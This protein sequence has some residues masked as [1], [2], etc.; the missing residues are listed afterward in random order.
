M[1]VFQ[2]LSQ[3]N[4]IHI[5]SNGKCNDNSNS[6]RIAIID[7]LKGY[8]II[9]VILGHMIVYTKP[10]NFESNFLFPLIYSFHMPL[11][12]AL[13][14]YL[15]Y[16]K[17]INYVWA[18]I[19]KKFKGLFI[20]YLVWNIIGLLIVDSF[21]TKQNIFQK[22]IESFYIYSNLWFLPV[23]FFSFILLIFYIFLE[24]LFLKMSIQKYSVPFYLI[25]YLIVMWVF[26]AQPPFQ[27]FL[28]IRWF[29]PFVF[30]GYITAKYKNYIF[31]FN[32]IMFPVSLFLF[33]ILLPFWDIRVIQFA[34]VG[35]T[36]LIINFILALFG[37]TISYYIVKLLKNTKIY[38]FLVFCGMFS[39]E[40]YVISNLLALIS[41]ITQ[42]RFW[43]GEGIVSLLSG[44]L[45]FTFISLI[46]SLILSYNQICSTLLFGRWVLKHP[47]RI[48]KNNVFFSQEL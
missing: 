24:K 21:L 7:A 9:L 18:F 13:S 5:N 16:S 14:G 30:V 17:S 6:K 10:D 32:K 43:F 11:L 45:T 42:I 31:N 37:I 23:L 46:L 2:G 12:L 29:S 15:V 44:T 28:A 8:A 34:E 33:L 36:H 22:I 3:S 4:S 47:L 40:I 27:G 35:F 26:F 25:I 19:T 1:A 41:T 39:L 48:I 20:P 38:T